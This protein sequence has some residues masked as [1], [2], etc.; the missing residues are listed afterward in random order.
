MQLKWLFLFFA[1]LYI[2][3]LLLNK[4]NFCLQDLKSSDE[5]NNHLLS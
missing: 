4:H 1:K 3:I 5:S 2:Y